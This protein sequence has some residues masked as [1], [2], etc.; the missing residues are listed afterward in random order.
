MECY[1]YDYLYNL[2]LLTLCV[3][4]FGAALLYMVRKA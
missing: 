4:I 3:A 2:F 1:S